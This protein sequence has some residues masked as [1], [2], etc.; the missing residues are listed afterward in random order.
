RPAP[1]RSGRWLLGCGR[2]HRRA[3]TISTRAFAL[4]VL[5]ALALAGAALPAAAQSVRVLAT[6]PPAGAVLAVNDALYLHLGYTADGP[7]R[8]RARAYRHGEERT[9]G[10]RTNPA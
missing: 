10:L 8:F 6:D 4:R 1:V 3:H 2:M 9:A 7:V 5:L